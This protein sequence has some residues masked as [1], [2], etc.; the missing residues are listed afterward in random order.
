[1]RNI[2]QLS[3]IGKAGNKTDMTRLVIPLYDEGNP[4]LRYSALFDIMA[5]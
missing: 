3:L 1:M 2:S 5:S 4:L